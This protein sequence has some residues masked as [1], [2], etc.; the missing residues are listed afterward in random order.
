MKIRGTFTEEC[1]GTASANKEIHREFIG[2]KAPDAK[3]TEEEVEAIGAEAVTE[4]S[5]TVFPRDEDGCPILWDY[6]LKGFLK[7]N[8]NALRE[9]EGSTVY[10]DCH[11]EKG[12]KRLTK[13]CYKRTVDNLIFVRPRKIRLMM[14]KGGVVGECQRPLRAETMRGERIALAHSETVPAGTVF[15]AEIVCLD[16]KL[17]PVVVELLN[18]GEWKG[19]GQ[20]RNSGKGRFTWEEIK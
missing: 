18:Y 5:M 1:L 2:S 20:W 19:L 7:D 9:I 3:S 4:K 11:K 10:I 16:K 15:E 12:G 6:Q 13:Y 14:P 17:E 8:I